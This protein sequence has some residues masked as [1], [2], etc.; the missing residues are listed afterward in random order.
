MRPSKM[1]KYV[2]QV[3]F[4]MNYILLK[5]AICFKVCLYFFLFQL[6][7]YGL[8]IAFG[9]RAQ[10]RVVEVSEL[11]REQLYKTQKMAVKNV[12]AIR[13]KERNVILILVQVGQTGM[14]SIFQYFFGVFNKVQQIFL[15]MLILLQL[16]IS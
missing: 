16:T 6:I 1:S 4:K 5:M 15:T 14:I 11:H 13:S 10:S 3:N 7:V 8:D 9:P 12:K 2:I